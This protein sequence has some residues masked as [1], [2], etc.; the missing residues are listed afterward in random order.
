M[1]T[2][3][4]CLGTISSYK[5]N[6]TTVSLAFFAYPESSHFRHWLDTEYQIPDRARYDESGMTILS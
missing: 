1:Y 2:Y 3:A 4:V 6:I 5:N